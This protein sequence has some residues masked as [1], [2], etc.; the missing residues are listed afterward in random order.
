MN[1]QGRP[2]APSAANDGAAPIAGQG[3]DLRAVERIIAA[4]HPH[5]SKDFALNALKRGEIS[6]KGK[7]RPIPFKEEGSLDRL[8]RGF[9]A[10]VPLQDR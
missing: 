10:V 9:D 1:R 2:T 5:P 7:R 8:V 3:F 6:R 4:A